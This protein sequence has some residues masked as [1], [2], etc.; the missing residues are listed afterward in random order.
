MKPSDF[1]LSGRQFFAY[2][3][4]GF[5][6]LAAFCFFAGHHPI[7]YI[8]ASQDTVGVIARFV[9]FLTGAYAIGFCAQEILFGVAT[10]CYEPSSACKVGSERYSATFCKF[11]VLEHSRQLNTWILEKEVWINLRVSIPP[12]LVAL[13]LG[14]L[15]YNIAWEPE[16]DYLLLSSLGLVAGIVS[17]GV[18]WV[19]P[20]PDMQQFKDGMPFLGL[21]QIR[22]R[23]SEEWCLMYKVLKQSAP[24]AVEEVDEPSTADAPE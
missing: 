1:Y 20:R 10:C 2:A 18:L 22:Q 21:S 12:S 3:V 23:E 5:I 13:S 19:Y 4:P 6:W 16:S 9:I 24:M 8:E 15:T 17:W 14:L 7:A 11:Y